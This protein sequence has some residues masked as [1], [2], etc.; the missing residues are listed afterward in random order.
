LNN[1]IAVEE[2][3]KALVCPDS[4]REKDFPENGYQDKGK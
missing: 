2:G 3:E 1:W 4:G